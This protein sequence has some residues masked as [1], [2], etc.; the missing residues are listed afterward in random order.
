MQ[1]FPL[2]ALLVFLL[3]FSISSQSNTVTTSVFFKSDQY[4][5]TE[6]EKTKLDSF[7][8]TLAGKPLKSIEIAGN[9]DSDADS[10]YNIRLSQNRTTTV[11]EY[12]K[13]NGFDH[14][15]FST[16]FFGENKPV[17]I[18]DAESG[19]QKNR[20][21][22]I[23]ATLKPVDINPVNPVP[24]KPKEPTLIIEK[25]AVTTDTCLSDTTILLPQGSRYTI[26]LCDY[27]KYKDCIK[28]TEYLTA[29]SIL[30]SNLT[31][32]TAS[33]QQLMTGGMADIKICDS[34]KLLKP[35]KYRIPVISM[36]T[37]DC[38]QKVTTR[39]M[40]FWGMDK[41]GRW[42][43]SKKAKKV[44]IND[45]LYYELQVKGSHMCNL[46]IPIP[47]APSIKT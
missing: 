6:T 5:L 29:E 15:L 2:L 18:N 8:A 16:A 20:R 41:N 25:E 45:T 22:D 9:T 19:K 43:S 7:I 31:T 38:D 30:N 1:N 39:E 12:L 46:D 34:V 17:A 11:R 14:A 42:I 10:L 4:D 28:V 27:R 23:I 24:D 36:K 37:N 21:V 47:K 35:L 13:K 33:G 3:P 32:L 40:L 26:N 44:L